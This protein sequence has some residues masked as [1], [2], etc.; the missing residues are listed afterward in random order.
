MRFE[1][2]Q[3]LRAISG[4]LSFTSTDLTFSPSDFDNDSLVC[5][6]QVILEQTQ[7]REEPCH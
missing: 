1:A 4:F 2:D 6:F 3:T 5:V 7:G